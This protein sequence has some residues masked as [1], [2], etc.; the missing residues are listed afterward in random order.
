MY[1]AGYICHADSLVIPGNI[2]LILAIPTISNHTGSS[3]YDGNGHYRN[4]IKIPGDKHENKRQCT[5]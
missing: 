2:E 1:D 3:Y 4:I 5:P